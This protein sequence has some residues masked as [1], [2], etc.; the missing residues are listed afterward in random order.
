MLIGISTENLHKEAPI[1]KSRRNNKIS[2]IVLGRMD[3]VNYGVASQLKTYRDSM[4]DRT[5]LI[6]N[7]TGIISIVFLTVKLKYK[8]ILKNHLHQKM[9]TKRFFNSC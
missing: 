6:I 3:K 8:D 1:L 2:P 4:V 5:T 9:P 7:N